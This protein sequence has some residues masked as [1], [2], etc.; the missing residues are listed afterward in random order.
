MYFQFEVTTVSRQVFDDD[1]ETGMKTTLFPKVTLCNQNHGVGYD[2]HI[3]NGANTRVG[4][5][6]NVG[7]SYH[8]PEPEQG[9]SFLAGS[10]YFQ[11][12]EIEVYQKE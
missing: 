8:N 9:E 7:S 10:Q 3:C 11:L 5:H 2:L 1:N 6:A 12:S 4:S